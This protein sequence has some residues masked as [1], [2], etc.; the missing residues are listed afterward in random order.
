MKTVDRLGA[1]SGALY[2]VMANVAIA[3][4]RNPELPEGLYDFRCNS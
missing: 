3:I 1:L 2:F 4:G